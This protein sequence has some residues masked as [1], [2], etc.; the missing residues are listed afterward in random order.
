MLNDVD[1][2][3][4]HEFERIR[5]RCDPNIGDV[6]ISCSGSVGR[7]ALVDRDYT[8][9][10]VRSAAM[11][12]PCNEN[13]NSQFL[14]IMLRSP[15]LQEQMRV[16][17]KQSAQANLFLG[18][19]GNLVTIIPPLEEQHRIVAKVDELMALCDQLKARLADAQT[20]QLHLTDAIVEQNV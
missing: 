17:S 16:R 19:I 9:S 10:M 20:T 8:Y 1:Y 15:Y 3:P 12:R 14:A 11:I 18:A 2:V 13:L 4:K 6:L 5:K 7:V